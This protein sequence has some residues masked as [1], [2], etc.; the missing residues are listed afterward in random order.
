MTFQVSVPVDI[1]D[2]LET[3]ADAISYNDDRERY[4]FIRHG[5]EYTVTIKITGQECPKCH[6]WM[7]MVETPDG[8]RG[9]GCLMCHPQYRLVDE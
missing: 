5:I 4:V 9:L 6:G 2:V 3:L 1:D 7:R 8:R